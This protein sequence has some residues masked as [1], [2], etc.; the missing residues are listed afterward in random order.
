MPDS[1]DLIVAS[2]CSHDFHRECLVLW[3]KTRATVPAAVSRCG[4]KRR[5]MLTRKEILERVKPKDSGT[6]DELQ[7]QVTASQHEVEA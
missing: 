6:N 7:G 5:T 3:L 1:D 2:P 4:I